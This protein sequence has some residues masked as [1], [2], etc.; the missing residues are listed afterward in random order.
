MRPS[1]SI[2]TYLAALPELEQAFWEICS[3][4][5]L[6]KG[7][8]FVRAGEPVH[9][10]AWISSGYLRAYQVDFAGK[11]TTLEF[12][13]PRSFCSSYYGFYA[14]EAAL[15]NLEAIT[16]VQLQMITYEQLIGLYE[17]YP[18]LNLMGR[19]MVEHVC[20][21]KE[22]RIARMLQYD[23]TQRYQWFLQAYAELVPV[24]QLQHIATFLGMTPVTLSRIRK[25]LIS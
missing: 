6:K 18:A 12:Y 25:S 7:T 14:R 8:Y 23:A 11:D 9:H 3:P 17:R 15:D 5:S 16:D 21:Q 22:L 24:A 4:L 13:V 1:L 10:I 2:E 19:K 20:I